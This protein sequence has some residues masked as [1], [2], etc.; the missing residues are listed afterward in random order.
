M[1]Q[2]Y[3]IAIVPP[4]PVLTSVQ[5]IKREIFD[6]YGTKG[7]LRSPGHITLHMPFSW[8]EEKEGKLVNELAAFKFD[9]P[10]AIQLK[11]F[12]CFEPRV[13]FLNV[14]ENETLFEMQKNLVKLAL[15]KLQLFNQSEDMRGFHPHVTVAFRDLKKPVFY[16]L[17]EKY[18][19]ESFEAEFECSSIC[20]LKH[21]DQNWEVYKEFGFCR[22]GNGTQMTLIG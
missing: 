3:F 6:A 16:K 1:Q 9:R 2:K 10:F 21:N 8:E 11:N 7:A 14:L 19:N 20:L 5:Q 18:K 17:W 15:Q 13:V 22:S 12:D 4:E